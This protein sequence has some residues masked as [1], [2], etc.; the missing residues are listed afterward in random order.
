MLAEAQRDAAVHRMGNLTLVTS[1][2]NQSV[3]N[4]AWTVKRPELADQSSLQL[5]VPIAS[6]HDWNET[7][8]SARAV[9]LAE[10]ACRVW[11]R[12]S[13]SPAAPPPEPASETAQLPRAQEPDARCVHDLPVVQCSLCKITSRAAAGPDSEV[14]VLPTSQ[15]FHRRSCH[16]FDASAEGTRVRGFQASDPTPVSLQEAVAKRLRPCEICSPNFR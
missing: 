10:I 11:P 5:N 3:S 9:A 6:I 2:F 4:F 7:H 12:R 15:V 8:I 16:V 1:T 14:W 13:H